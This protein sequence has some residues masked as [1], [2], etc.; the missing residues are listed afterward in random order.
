MTSPL[1][2][3]LVAEDLLVRARRNELSENERR[4]LRSLLESSKELELLYLAGVEFDRAGALVAGDEER[5]R[6]LVELGLTHGSAG[7]R[8]DRAPAR[9][10][11]SGNA[12]RAAPARS[13][14]LAL[15]VGALL[16]AAVSAAFQYA[17]PYFSRGTEAPLSHAAAGRVA[18]AS[19]IRSLPAPLTA[20]ALTASP[21]ASTTSGFVTPARTVPHPT[22]PPQREPNATISVL[23]AKAAEARRNGDTKT[24]IRLYE[25]LCARYPASIEAADARLSLGK[26]KLEQRSAAEALEHFENYPPGT[27]SVEALWGRAEALRQLSSPAERATLERIVSEYPGSPYAMAARK[28]LE[29]P[30]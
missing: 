4:R 23:F 7:T 19:R 2:T 25:S 1:D 6:R 10:S 12:G 30:R 20:P 16:G 29:S 27:L 3:D 18:S 26:L 17:T 13:V 24:A 15:G 8:R 5:M 21:T 9:L 11:R 22:R 28:R 14:A